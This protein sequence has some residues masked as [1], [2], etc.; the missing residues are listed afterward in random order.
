MAQIQMLC[1]H[2]I[3]SSEYEFS[4]K[5]LQFSTLKKVGIKQGQ[6][7]WYEKPRVSLP[8]QGCQQVISKDERQR[9]VVVEACYLEVICAMKKS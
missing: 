3:T 9:E 2:N 7:Q 4:K 5:N 8:L 1:N 6:K